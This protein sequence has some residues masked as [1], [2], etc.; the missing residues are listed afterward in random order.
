M[1]QAGISSII[2]ETGRFCLMSAQARTGFIR[3]GAGL[4]HIIILTFL[5]SNKT[6]ISTKTE[7]SR[8]GKLCRASLAIG[9]AI[10]I[11]Q[12]AAS[13]R[14]ELIHHVLVDT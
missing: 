7:W 10:G 6:A 2:R 3:I 9:N 13:V 11:E 12:S 1:A 4:L 14:A 5:S 8:M